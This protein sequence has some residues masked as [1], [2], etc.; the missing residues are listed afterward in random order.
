MDGQVD[1]DEVA[2]AALEPVDRALAAVVGAVVDDP[3]DAPGGGVG[4][5]GHHL[6]D[7]VVEWFDAALGLAAVEQLRPPHV[8]GGQVAERAHPLVL[9]LD[10][11]PVTAGKRRRGRM[12]AGARLD[13]RLLVGTEDELAWVQELALEAAGVE[14]EH[15]RCLR[16]EVG[17]AGEDPG[18]VLPGFEGVLAQPPP[19]RRG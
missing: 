12:Q 7:Q 18:P 3:E 14:V 17:V 15:P 9:V 11:L 10:Q 4:L 5:L 2:P 1:E 8:P 19:D 13:R 6:G 16:P